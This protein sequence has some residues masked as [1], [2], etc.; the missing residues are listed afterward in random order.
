MSVLFKIIIKYYLCE[1][2]KIMIVKFSIDIAAIK[3][4]KKSN[5]KL[6]VI[7][8]ITIKNSRSR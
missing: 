4:D 8:I 3:T 1:K 5:Y 2:K 6:S 7:Q